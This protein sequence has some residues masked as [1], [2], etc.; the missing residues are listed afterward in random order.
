MIGWGTV[1]MIIFLNIIKHVTEGHI[2]IKYREPENMMMYRRG[3]RSTE[4]IRRRFHLRP[5]LR[6]Q[7]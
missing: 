2:D 3:L 5:P 7:A 6:H 4:S 1:V